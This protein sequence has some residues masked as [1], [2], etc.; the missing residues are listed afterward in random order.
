MVLQAGGETGREREREGELRKC[1]GAGCDGLL[2]LVSYGGEDGAGK[3][4]CWDLRNGSGGG[5]GHVGVSCVWGAGGD[6]LGGRIDAVG[7][8]S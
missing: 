7:L 8:P 3:W 2:Q 4:Q 6:L 1:P 5:S